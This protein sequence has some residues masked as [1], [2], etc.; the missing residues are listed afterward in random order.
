MISRHI[1]P[2]Q[3]APW[4]VSGAAGCYIMARARQ[5]SWARASRTPWPRFLTQ[6][7][8]VVLILCGSPAVWYF[9]RRRR[10]VRWPLR[11]ADG[12]RAYLAA[13]VAHQL[14]QVFTV[15]LLGLGMIV[16]K[17]AEGKTAE[18]AALARRLQHIARGG[19]SIL[20]ALDTPVAELA[21]VAIELN[22]AHL[23]DNGR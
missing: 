5:L 22:R 2:G 14:R 20:A 7:L 19:A 17:A 6:Q 18:L 23:P 21:P 13:G 1:P 16:R 8:D 4:L 12:D 3:F 11:A 15:L 10:T 9:A